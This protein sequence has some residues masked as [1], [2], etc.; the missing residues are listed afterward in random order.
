MISRLHYITQ[1]TLNKTHVQLAEEACAVG[2]NWVQLRLKNKPAEEWEQI[3]TEVQAV[4]KKYN[5][6][7][8]I[9][10]NVDL[11]KKIAADGVHLGKQDMPTIEARKILGNKFIIGGTANTFEDIKMHTAAGVNYIGLGPFRFTTT[12]EKLSPVLGVEGYQKIMLQC[13]SEQINTPIIA[14]GGIVVNDVE[15]IINTGIYGV[16]VAGAITHSVNKM[17]TIH[18]FFNALKHETVNYSK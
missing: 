17:Q 5:A 18:E 10:D 4:C 1:D 13:K 2:A 8:I 11:V 15:S 16:A 6:T 9:N 12:K 14:I 7:F 3:A